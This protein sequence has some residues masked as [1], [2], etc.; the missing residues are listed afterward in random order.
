ML[1]EQLFDEMLR[2]YEEFRNKNMEIKALWK[3]Y[4][5][6]NIAIAVIGFKD[7]LEKRKNDLWKKILRDISNGVSKE[8]YYKNYN[9]LAHYI[10]KDLAV[11][12]K[13]ISEVIK[14]KIKSGQDQGN[15]WRKNYLAIPSF[16]IE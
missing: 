13:A 6:Y 16:E 3:F 10:P 8:Q 12:N 9:K 11:I 14:D 15:F 5:C 4:S 7:P 2:L 1:I